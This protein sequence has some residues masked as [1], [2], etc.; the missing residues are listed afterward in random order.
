MVGVNVMTKQVE[1][2]NKAKKTEE[3]GRKWKIFEPF[4]TYPPAY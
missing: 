2:T 1:R 4:Q 3:N